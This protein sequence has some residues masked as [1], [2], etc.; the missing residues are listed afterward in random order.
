[1]RARTLDFRRLVSTFHLGT[2]AGELL[3]TNGRDMS[4]G[5]GKALH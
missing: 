1:V 2:Y 3:V 5:D 4:G